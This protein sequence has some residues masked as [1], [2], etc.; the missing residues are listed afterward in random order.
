MFA[1]KKMKIWLPTLLFTLIS[2]TYSIFLPPFEGFD[3]PAHM[4]SVLSFATNNGRPI[5]KAS[6]FH[7]TVEKAMDLVP[8]PVDQFSFWKAQGGM[9]MPTGINY[10]ERIKR[11][12][13]KTKIVTS[14]RTK[15]RRII[16][17]RKSQN[18]FWR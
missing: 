18:F 3:E 14:S 7:K 11:P 9:S 10:P 13:K 6:F 16:N 2:I 12:K 17:V 8:G 5:P 15:R 1:S 4:V